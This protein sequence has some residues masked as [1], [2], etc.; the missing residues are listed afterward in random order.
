M[1]TRRR[2]LARMSRPTAVVA[3]AT[4][5][6]LLAAGGVL[7]V[8]RAASLGPVAAPEPHIQKDADGHF[9]ARAEV[10]GR[11]MRLLVDTGA[12]QVALTA[13]DAHALGLDPARMIYDHSVA[14][15]SGATRAARVTL[16]RLSVDG[17]EV[18]DVTALVVER[19]LATSLLG[20]SYLGRLH[21]FSADRETLT[22][23]P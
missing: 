2:H 16:A 9:W 5:A 18:E 11:L 23:R 10:D 14:T 1:Q 4:A 20:M 6:A 17:A 7:S 15:A 19:G 12:S 21:G 13:T 8:G 3:V 22:L